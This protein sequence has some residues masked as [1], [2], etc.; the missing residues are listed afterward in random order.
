MSTTLVGPPTVSR[1][2]VRAALAAATAAGLDVHALTT[3]HGLRLEELE[4]P[5]FRCPHRAWVALWDDIERRTGEG[6]GLRA[7][8]ELPLQW[9]AVD[10]LFAA[11]PTLGTAL[12]RVERYFA[13][14]ST[15]VQH[16]LQVTPSEARLVRVMRPG[17]V[18]S[19]A[20][21]EFAFATLV[22]RFRA[23]AAAPWRPQ[24]IDFVHAPAAPL[25][26][27]QRVFE[28]PVRF[29]Q[30][31]DCIV[32]SVEAL[33]IPMARAAPELCM[34]LESHLT[35]LAARIPGSS[36]GWAE[37]VASVLADELRGGEPSLSRV[38][39]RLG[40]SARSLQRR[41][42]EIGVPYRV[43]LARTRDELARRYL[44]ESDI[45]LG[46]VAFMLGFADTSAFY[47]SFRRLRGETPGEF[48]R[49]SRARS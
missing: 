45:E 38:A 48:R 18:P 41:L 21:T 33:A 15:A 26:H 4:Q 2:T 47:K 35:S 44:A 25:E 10:Y 9:D 3:Q 5:E 1:K 14:V 11:S 12:G 22:R 40:V 42:T 28:C 16:V 36:L 17:S 43:L 37:R 39:H 6:V 46:E 31:E 34:V 13:L 27:Y 19:R 24:R 32:L 23:L 20:A 49:R 8:S 30:A 7:G 29:H